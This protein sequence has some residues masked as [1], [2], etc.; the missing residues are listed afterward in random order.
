MLKFSLEVHG[1]SFHV[2][3]ITTHIVKPN[4]VYIQNQRMCDNTDIELCSANIADYRGCF[5]RHV[6]ISFSHN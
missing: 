4:L 6:C 5:V 3:L 2:D 1:F